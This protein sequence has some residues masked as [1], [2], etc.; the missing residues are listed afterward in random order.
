M[1]HPTP[2]LFTLSGTAMASA[3]D[4]QPAIESTGISSAQS[5]CRTFTFLKEKCKINEIEF[6]EL[7]LA[8]Q[9]EMIFT[10]QLNES[11]ENYRSA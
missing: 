10:I 5:G 3:F 8:C 1:R 4:L 9:L 2:L 7:N 11:V 6:Q